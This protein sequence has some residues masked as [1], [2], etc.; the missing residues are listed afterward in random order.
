MK[1]GAA[2]ADI[3]PPPGM[4]M[5]PWSTALHDCSEANELDL[6]ATALVLGD[7]EPAAVMIDLDLRSLLHAQA[8]A[9]RAAV[10]EAV[11]LEADRVRVT[12]TH[13]H[14]TPVTNELGGWLRTGCERIAPYFARVVEASAE[15]AREARDRLAPAVAGIATAT[16]ELA[17]NRRE[18]LPTGE[19]RVGYAEDGPADHTVRV[20]RLDDLDGTAIAT[21]VGY[22][23]HPI[24]LGGANRIITPEYPGVVRR[25]VESSVGGHC[26]FLQGAAGDVG[27]R[28]ALVGEL[29]PYHRQGAWLGHAAAS[30]AVRASS[31]TRRPVARA[32]QE[33]GSWLGAHEFVPVAD[34]DPVLGSVIRT[35]ELRVRPGLGDPRELAAEAERLAGELYAERERGIDP[36]SERALIARTK[37]AYMTTE[38]AAALRGRATFPLEVHGVRIGPAAFV[39]VPVELFA[40]SGRAICD[41]SPSPL[42]L[43]TGYT[44]GYRNYVPSARAWREGG[45][46][47]DIACFAED[48]A[49]AIEDA[50]ASVLEELA[51]IG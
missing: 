13:S 42:T 24:I 35:V 23:A 39:G 21:L 20:L 15:A 45:Y 36:E 38:R 18:R 31:R 50:A 5:G 1:A 9:V 37:W 8:D 40:D 22:A 32:R 26:L 51:G 7:P 49:E 10:A 16:C 27:P 19:L 46:E 14:S 12:A 2:R 25:V 34:R 44:N 48:A 6:R 17:V 33:S 47:V 4:P 30:A 11:G 3:T 41:R 43:V 28:E 29:E